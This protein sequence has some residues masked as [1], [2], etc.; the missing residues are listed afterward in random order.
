[1]EQLSRNAI[2][3]SQIKSFIGRYFSSSTE[4]TRN[5]RARRLSARPKLVAIYYWM[6]WYFLSDDD[7]SITLD[8]LIA[9]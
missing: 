8:T 7:L 6:I 5:S 1:M 4:L 2:D 9:P 3:T